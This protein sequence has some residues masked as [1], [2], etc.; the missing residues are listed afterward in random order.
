MSEE[1]H[2]EEHSSPIK[3][4]GQLIAVVVL[5]FI[6]PI[7][8]IAM[9]AHLAISS[10]DPEQDKA[11]MSDEAVA[12]RLKPVGEVAV[13]DPNAPVMAKS[14]KEVYDAV[15]LACHGTGALNAPKVGDKSAWGKLLPQGLEKLTQS[16]IKG[17]KQ[18]PPRG[19]NPDLS[20]LELARAIVLMANQSGGN[21]KEPADKP[22]AKAG[23]KAEKPAPA[24]SAPKAEASKGK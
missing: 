20:D 15:C 12:K 9:L 13:A 19:G 23:A 2:V 21:L 6:I 17:V 3:T 4:P 8:V 5:A 18:M 10:L 24:K 22:A 1:L 14:G 7:T 11:A 16:A